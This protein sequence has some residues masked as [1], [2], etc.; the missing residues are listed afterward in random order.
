MKRL[1]IL[2]DID[3]TISS[4]DSVAAHGFGPAGRDCDPRVPALVRRHDI[5]LFSRNPELAQWMADLGCAGLAKPPPGSPSLGLTG[6]DVLIDD[7]ADLFAGHAP[8]VRLFLSLDA[9]FNAEK[10]LVADP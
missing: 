9:F 2:L 10:S 8:G 6:F 7:E 5:T 1:N 3:G 4:W